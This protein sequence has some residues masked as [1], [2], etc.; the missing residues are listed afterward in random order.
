MMEQLGLLEVLLPKLST[1]LRATTSADGNPENTADRAKSGRSRPL[2]RP[3]RGALA[4]ADTGVPLRRYASNDRGWCGRGSSPGL[5]RISART[6]FLARRSDHMRLLLEA[7][8]H[9]MTQSRLARRIVRRPYY[10]EARHFFELIAPT[11]DLEVTAFDRFLAEARDYPGRHRR[12]VSGGEV[13]THAGAALGA[14]T[15]NGGTSSSSAPSTSGAPGRRRRRRRGGRR[16]R[17]SSDVAT[18]VLTDAISSPNGGSDTDGPVIAEQ[19]LPAAP[20]T[21]EESAHGDQ[22]R[23]GLPGPR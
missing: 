12:P 16:R 10:P 3:R 19:S 14:G 20:T 22:G 15:P 9:M 7:A 18:I 6:R 8:T 1:H 23:G 21:G 17:P 5:G 4:T 2:N 11:Y 13:Q